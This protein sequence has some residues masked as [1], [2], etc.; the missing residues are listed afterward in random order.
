MVVSKLNKSNKSHKSAKKETSPKKPVNKTPSKNHRHK[1]RYKK[2]LQFKDL[3]KLSKKLKSQNKK[4]IFTIGSFDILNP[5][6]CRYLAEAKAAGDVLV[7]GIS[8]D[9]SDRRI[10]GPN[11]PLISDQI[12]SE[13]VS[14]LKS[15]D[16]VTVIDNDRPQATLIMLQ[17]DVFFTG[18]HD[19][20]TGLRT[21]QDQ[22]ILDIYGGEIYVQKKYEPYFSV[23]DLVEHIASIRVLQ[24]LENY[25]SGKL[26]DFSLNL[27]ETLRPADFGLQIPLDDRAFNANDIIF[28]PDNLNLEEISQKSKKTAKKIVFVAGSYDLLHVGHA[29]FIEQASLLGDIIVVGIPSDVSVHQLKGDGRPVI[30]ERS[31]AYVLSHL[32]MVDNVVIFPEIGVLA[33]LKKLKPDIFYTVK[34][35]WNKNYKKSPE[36]KAVIDYG[37]KVVCGPKQSS[38]I[39]ASAII[40]KV[41]QEKVQ[42]VFKECMDKTRYEAILK[43]R[44]RLNGNGH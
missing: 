3:Q 4:I 5:G 27:D 10:K 42:E 11:Y 43:E 37:G 22:A 13:L 31:R 8:S 17:P 44:S 6:Q 30:S 33:T 41:A 40:D 21:E 2:L 9:E 35:S 36:Y 39:S 7:V 18:E 20:E 16:Y 38:N 12:R 15:V 34:D 25:L 32:D 24:I 28:G 23:S 29:R 26:E 1:N 19:W 14:Y